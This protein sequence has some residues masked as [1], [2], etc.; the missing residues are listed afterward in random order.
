MSKKIDLAIKSSTMVA[1]MRLSHTMVLLQTNN[2]QH[3]KVESTADVLFWSPQA[4]WL[5]S[6]NTGHMSKNFKTWNK[7]LQITWPIILVCFIG[8]LEFVA[9]LLKSNAYLI[10][11]FANF[12]MLKYNTTW[13]KVSLKPTLALLKNQTLL[14]WG[15]SIAFLTMML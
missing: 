11:V 8:I 3:Q 1:L 10:D 4:F 14:H 7:A 5:K 9:Y 12:S 15:V 6:S 2:L 13:P